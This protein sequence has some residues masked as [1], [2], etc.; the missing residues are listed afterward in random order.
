[1]SDQLLQLVRVDDDVQRADLGES[2]LLG[3]DARSVDLLPCAGRVCL[4]RR[5]NGGLELVEV[6][7]AGCEAREV[8][9]GVEEDLRRLV[10]RLGEATLGD[11]LD[12]ADVRSGDELLQLGVHLALGVG[13]DERRVNVRL[14]DLLAA[15]GQVLDQLRVAAHLVGRVDDGGVLGGV[16][17]FDEGHNALLDHQLGQLRLAEHRPHLLLVYAFSELGRALDGLDVVEQDLSRLAVQLGL[18]EDDESLLVQLRAD[19]DV[20]D[21]G[22]VVIVE[23]VDVVHDARC[24]GLDGGEDEQVLQITVVGELGVLQ[25][26]LLEQFDELVWQVGRHEG[27]DRVRHNVGV[28]GLG[29]RV[30]HDGVDALAAVLVALNEHGGPEV[31]VLPLDKVA[32]LLLEEAVAVSHV[33]QLLVALSALVRDE[34]EV[35]VALLAVGADDGRVVVHV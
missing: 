33:D 32:S 15:H 19:G 25:H 23:P 1:M 20:G 6:D 17:G 27:L 30:L 11:V 31:L 13:E 28:L 24:V 16:S 2:E 12:T 10:H 3:L 29:Q 5:V 7:Q 4:A 34:G 22:H 9:D 26:D 21:V 14:L 35:G 8:G 18:L